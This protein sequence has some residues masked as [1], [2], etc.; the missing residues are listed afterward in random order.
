L[1]FATGKLHDKAKSVLE[2]FG[3]VEVQADERTLAECE[4]LVSWPSAID[5]GLVSRMKS[6]RVIQTISAGVDDIDFSS[7]RPGVRV[8]SNAGAYTEFASEHAW[9]L[10]LAAAKGVGARRKVE[11]YLLNGKTLL[12]IGCGSI[13]S[14]AARIGK[15]A[16]GMRT[17]GVSRSFKMPHVFDRTLPVSGLAGV[18]SDAD[19]VVVALPLNVQT[20]SLLDYGMLSRAKSRI[21]IV[22][23]GRAEVVDL[24]SILRILHE[25]QETRFATDVFWRVG[26][27]EDFESRIW[28]EPNFT[29]T[30]H[31]AGGFGSE[32]ALRRAEL[33]AAENVRHLLT[34]GSAANE[35][36]PA[37]YI[38]SGFSQS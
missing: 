9:G 32:E 14:E 19:A 36:N 17:V 10:L 37:D 13:G 18:M 35:V 20:R 24:P 34:T 21:V 11:P 30:L 15:S 1:I 26:T 3:L 6:L 8:F 12:V 38:A 23:V 4:I 7:L 22:N 31:T 16:F 27:K 2:G 29:G 25:R 28:D 33:A 5:W